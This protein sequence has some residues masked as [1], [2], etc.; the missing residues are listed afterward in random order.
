[1]KRT[2]IVL[3]ISM[4][5]LASCATPKTNSDGSP[6]WT[7]HSPKNTKA[8]HYEVA[9]AKQ[10]TPQL[11]QLRAESSAKDAIGRWA[12]TNVDNAL[13]TFIEEAGEVL[14]TK[15]MLEV[16]QNLSIQTVNIGLRGVVFEER[17]TAPDGTVWVLASYPVKNLKDAY[18]KQAVE[19]EQRI[20]LAQANAQEAQAK[21][22]QAEAMLAFLDAQLDR[23]IEE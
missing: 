23:D 9:S 6:Y 17:Y 15:Q 10:S 22:I 13:V 21:A 19:L 16:L 20:A 12:S 14:K 18:K 11:S 7:T 4:L 5:L 3:L 2:L 8:I 1:M